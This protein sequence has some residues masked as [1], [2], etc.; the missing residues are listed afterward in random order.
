MLGKQYLRYCKE[1]KRYR[2]EGEGEGEV[3]MGGSLELGDR[4]EDRKI[5]E[6]RSKLDILE[7]TPQ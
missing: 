6:I 2:T 1:G 4:D 5:S 3:V 7:Q